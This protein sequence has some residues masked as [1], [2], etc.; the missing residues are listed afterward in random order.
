[1]LHYTGSGG[2]LASFFVFESEGFSPLVLPEL[3]STFPKQ[4]TNVRS[5]ASWPADGDCVHHL[6]VSGRTLAPTNGMSREGTILA[7]LAAAA[8]RM[9]ET[10]RG[11][12]N[13][14]GENDKLMG[15]PVGIY[16]STLLLLS[17]FPS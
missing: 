4:E 17:V 7:P 2:L 5:S 8:S 14:S 1:M 11:E 9:M 15:L 6:K 3:L 16:R 12:R 10:K 13:T